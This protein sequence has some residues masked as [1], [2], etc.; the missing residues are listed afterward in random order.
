MLSPTFK[1]E[2]NSVLL[3]FTTF[4]FASILISPPI[5]TLL[6]SFSFAAVTVNT[7]SAVKFGEPVIPTDLT[8]AK[9][10]SVTPFLSGEF[11][12]IT[13]LFELSS[14]TVSP[15]AKEPD[16][17]LNTTVV[18]TDCSKIKSSPSVSSTRLNPSS[19]I[20][21]SGSV[22]VLDDIASTTPVAPE[23]PPVRVSPVSNS[24]ELVTP[25]CVNISTLNKPNL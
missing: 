13:P 5:V 9:S 15:V 23:V 3:P 4:E 8:C 22:D 10:N 21:W 24:T 12:T 7:V 1:S 19:V 25:T 20:N 18:N 14:V 11:D 17:L 16:T 2:L 6:S